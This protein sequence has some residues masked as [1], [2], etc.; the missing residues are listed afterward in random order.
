MSQAEVR[1]L[2]QFKKRFLKLSSTLL[3]L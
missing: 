1:N 3:V 2:G